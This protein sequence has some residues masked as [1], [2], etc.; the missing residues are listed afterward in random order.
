MCVRLL[1]YIA[2]Q[3]G[4]HPSPEGEML[5]LESIIKKDNDK[6]IIIALIFYPKN[7]LLLVFND[8]RFQVKEL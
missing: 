2:D 1:T 7:I 6:T 8:C 4:Y 3:I 5:E